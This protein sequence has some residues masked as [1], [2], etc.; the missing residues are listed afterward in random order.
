MNTYPETFDVTVIGGGNAGLEAAPIAAKMGAK[1]LLVTHSFER[2]GEQSCN[3]SIGG[4]GKSH[5][6]KEIDALGGLMAVVTDHA[7]IQFR[8]LNAS[9][10][11][12]VQ[13]TRAQIDRKI[14][15]NHMHRQVWHIPGL[16][17]FQAAADSLLIEGGKVTGVVLDNGIKVR[18]KT[19]IL[20]AGT[21]LNGKMFVGLKSFPGGRINDPPSTAL[22]ECLAQL[23]LPR[24]RLKTGT[25]ARLDGRTI[26]FNKCK[27]QLGDTNPVPVFSYMGSPSQHPMQVPCWITHTN[28][29]THDIIR[30]GLGTSPLFT[31]K[32]EGI[33]P[34]YCPSIEDKIHRFADKTSHHV[35]LEPEGLDTTVFYPNGISTSLDC[36]VQ[37]DFIRTI[38]GLENVRI[39]RPGYAIE[40][41]FYDPTALKASLE[42]KILENLFLAGQVNGTT[43][44]EEAAAQ[45]IYAGINAVLKSRDQEPFILGRDQA[46][47]G[48]MI[49]DLITKG[50]NEPY[51]M[52]TSRAEFRLSLREDNAD[53][54][55]TEIGR[56]LG[57][58]D[59][60]RW[61]YYCQKCDKLEAE[62]ERLKSI[63]VN[64]GVL[65]ETSKRMLGGDLQK[66]AT[67]YALLKR[68]Q[69][70]YEKLRHLKP[71]AGAP[72]LQ[73]P[74][75]DPSLGKLLNTRVKYAGYIN[76]QKEEVKRDKDRLHTK[77]PENFNYDEVK[78]LSFEICQKLKKIRPQTIGQALSISGVTPAA[79]SI[80][81]VYLKRAESMAKK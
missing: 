15:K 80:L 26:D 67:L 57:S 40:Y 72:F 7:G 68:P 51:R 41:D 74:T 56:K 4:I 1:T 6:V 65:N 36:E 22:A 35:F 14:Y 63:W 52:F 59:D 12:A 11:A 3:P 60:R 64:P 81:L 43:G 42:S 44:Y 49:D 10:G 71:V 13:A 19:V 45:G 75:L 29:K 8:I 54:R 23:G 2:F 31:G 78:G 20:T 50:V 39:L 16:M 5:L 9:K 73:E 62:E 32:I 17:H 18:S 77:I 58:V 55:L 47:L 76:R 46:Y 27:I 34:R 33:G 69:M 25:P 70:D 48:V 53:L 28:E 38:P 66:E 61:G 37:M 30:A 21:F 79:V 24:A